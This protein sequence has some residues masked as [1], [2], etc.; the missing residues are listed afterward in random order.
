MGCRR[1]EP[2]PASS[3]GNPDNPNTS[4]HT[5]LSAEEAALL[6]LDEEARAAHFATDAA[7]LLIHDAEPVLF[8]REGA[9]L[10]MTRVELTRIYAEDMRGATYHEWDYMEPPIV[11]VSDD[12]T[13]GWVITRR[14]VRRT[15]RE[16]DGTTAEQE[17]VYAGINAYEKRD[18][19][20]VR[21]A[22]VSTFAD[23]E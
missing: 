1:E 22:N 14:K 17:F 2:V 21:V 13:L 7:A 4:S 19:V 15:K 20:W 18:G 11:R 8:V 3:P 16:D 10:P 9:I 12:A 6:R 23:D 5:D